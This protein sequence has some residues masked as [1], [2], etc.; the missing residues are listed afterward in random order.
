LPRIR[1]R[2]PIRRRKFPT[3]DEFFRVL[4]AGLGRV[5]GTY[6]LELALRGL[7]AEVATGLLLLCNAMV[8]DSGRKQS[9][10]AATAPM[11]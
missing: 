9:V 1:Y 4:P 7:Q 11:S 8:Y 2:L 10:V 6:N 3:S 5:G